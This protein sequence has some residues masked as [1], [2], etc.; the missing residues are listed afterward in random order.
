MICSVVSM[1][2]PLWA[3]PAVSKPKNSLSVIIGGLGDIQYSKD[4]DERLAQ[5]DATAVRL[6]INII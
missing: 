1:I 3:T 5:H 4:I 6:L 2:T